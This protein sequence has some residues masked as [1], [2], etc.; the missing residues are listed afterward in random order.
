M[1]KILYAFIFLL[2]I[3]ISCTTDDTQNNYN[4]T[5]K[6]LIAELQNDNDLKEIV[7]KNTKFSLLLDNKLRNNEIDDNYLTQESVDVNHLM[8]E[9]AI[10]E[11]YEQYIKEIDMHIANINN[12]YSRLNTLPEGSLMSILIDISNNEISDSYNDNDIYKFGA[13]EIDCDEQFEED[14]QSIMDEYRSSVIL[15]TITTLFSGGLASVCYV[16]AVGNTV[17]KSAIAIDRHT[18]CSTRSF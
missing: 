17:L 7:S 13:G 4:L 14:M 3:T 1:R 16:A 18:L 10:V 11:E 12:K 8:E 9:L 15:C 2:F 5:T 6:E